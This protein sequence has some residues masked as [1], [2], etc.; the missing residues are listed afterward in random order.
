MVTHVHVRHV[1]RRSC[2]RAF[3]FEFAGLADGLGDAK[4]LAFELALLFEFSAVVHAAPKRPEPTKSGTPVVRRISLSPI[5]TDDFYW[6]RLLI[7]PLYARAR[8]LNSG[9]LNRLASHLTS[10]SYFLSGKFS[11]LFLASILQFVDN[12]VVTIG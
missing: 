5:Y 10:H 6:V 4:T 7:C 3:A 2:C 1:P 12:L 9:N 8:S 11:C